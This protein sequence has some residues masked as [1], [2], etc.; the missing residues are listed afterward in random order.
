M[1]FAPGRTAA[2]TVLLATGL[3]AQS[4]TYTDF[5]STAQ[6]SLLGTAAQSGTAL[7][8]T[9]N[10]SNQTGWFWRQGA[11]P[12]V[13]GFDTTF[14]F[15]IT[16][17]AVGT[18]AEGM[19]LVIH[20]DPN[21]VATQGGTVWGM[22]YGTGANTAVGIRNSIAIEFDTYQDGF[23]SDSSANEVTIHTRGA[24]GN[25]ENEQY[26]I[27]RATPAQNLANGQVH[28]LRVRYVPGTIEVFV[29]GATTPLISR[30]YDLVTGG[31]YAS[32]TAAPGANMVNGTAI[33]GFCA[34]TGAGT[35]T[36]LVE[37]LSWTWNSTPL[38]PAC[39]A[40][41][42]PQ[43]VLRIDGS[44][45]GL[46]RKVQ[47][48]T[49]QPF[50]IGIDVTSAA[51]PG[52]PYVLFASLLPQPGAF[53]TSLG[54][55]DM[56]F[57]VLP[58]GATELVLVDG[59]GLFPALLP[60]PL[61]PTTI[62]IPPAVVT[63]PLQLTMQAVTIASLSP[64]A[65]GVSNAVDVAFVPS[66]AP[67]IGTV[68]PLSAQAGAAVTITG[69]RFVPGCTLLVNGTPVV[70]TSQTTTQIVF[71]YPAGTPCG[72]TVAV[73]NPDGQGAQTAF[74]PTPVVTSTLLATGPAAG[75]VTFIVQG[76]GFSAGSTVTIGGA[77]ATVLS[78]GAT[79]MTI[80]TPPGT[81]GVAPV[82]ITTAGGC[83]ANTSYTYQ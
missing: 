1:T 17:P 30:A 3:V 51:G 32:G 75:N 19:A 61:A 10:T 14:T 66:L 7:R 22:G 53:G 40:G 65:L 18:K 12:V 6:L 74:N 57:P 26:S 60:A 80:R 59:F 24:Q 15:R 13:A 37:I 76:T 73:V 46:L 39:Y 63:F 31:L 50:G 77:P 27:A 58:T 56:C 5:S 62:P 43:D 8:L 4:F 33:A 38:T 79:V 64:F 29:D 35:L 81:P 20:D 48:A 44:T 71:P 34:T 52:M 47:L 9:A 78:A 68:L 42:L 54:F 83:V 72:S 36:E 49:Y 70:P 69:Q 82:V 11:L 67:S 41:S 16:P 23:L 25:N 45:G 21:G 2:V 55:G 28:S